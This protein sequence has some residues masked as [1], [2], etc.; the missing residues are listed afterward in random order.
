MLAIRYSP[1]RHHAAGRSYWYTLILTT[2]ALHLGHRPALPERRDIANPPRAHSPDRVKRAARAWAYAR[3]RTS[4]ESKSMNYGDIRTSLAVVRRPRSPALRVWAWSLICVV[5]LAG[6]HYAGAAHAS[7]CKNNPNHPNCSGDGGGGGGGGGGGEQPSERA[8]GLAYFNTKTERIEL[9]DADGLNRAELGPGG[10]RPRWSPDG[11]RLAFGCSGVFIMDVATRTTTNHT[12]AELAISGHCAVDWLPADVPGA[13]TLREPHEAPTPLIV[14]IGGEPKPGARYAAP[15]DSGVY[16]LNP[17]TGRYKELQIDWPATAEGLGWGVISASANSTAFAV[18]RS[19][20]N[21]G[22]R[23]WIVDLATGQGFDVT[24]LSGNLHWQTHVSYGACCT[25][26]P[27]R[28]AI[29]IASE[30]TLYRLDFNG[31]YEPLAPITIDAPDGAAAIWDRRFPA[32]SPDMEDIIFQVMSRPSVTSK[33]VMNEGLF[34]LHVSSGEVVH[35]V[36]GSASPLW[37]HWN[38][39]WTR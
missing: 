35:I 21:N 34:R 3:Q 29:A 16:L 15:E 6:V 5:W 26:G 27:F 8:P 31:A 9:V 12:P 30:G 37:A 18:R 17:D 23:L 25:D 11:T 36:P 28:D 19:D 22:D 14:F 20:P 33:R 13:E 1:S 4:Q 32:W 10:S 38:P 7:P 39:S 2:R 24:P